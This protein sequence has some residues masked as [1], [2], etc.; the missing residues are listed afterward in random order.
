[1][2]KEE[3]QL[4]VAGPELFELQV[5]VA[6]LELRIIETVKELKALINNRVD[7]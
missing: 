2:T 1:M 7:E 5:R 6:N 4:T 3:S